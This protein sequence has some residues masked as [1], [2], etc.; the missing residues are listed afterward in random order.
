MTPRPYRFIV[1]KI[2]M[3]TLRTNPGAWLLLILF[4][5][6]HILPS[7][8]VRFMLCVGCD[9]AGYS[10]NLTET[11]WGVLPDPCCDTPNEPAQEE[12]LSLSMGG[13][14]SAACDCVLLTINKHDTSAF[15]IQP[16]FSGPDRA[17]GH[18]S[19][20]EN[21]RIVLTSCAV[22]PRGPPDHCWTPIPPTLLDQRTGLIL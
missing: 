21:I 14:V 10:V 13:E 17:I 7:G 6:G 15:P 18:L 16:Q 2:T 4:S 1:P 20:D 8:A 22:S 5:I 19:A 9:D 12:Q 11:T 3:S